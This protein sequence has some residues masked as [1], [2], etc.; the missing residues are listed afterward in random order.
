MS[1]MSSITP[2]TVAEGK[3]WRAC[4]RHNMMA[5][6]RSRLYCMPNLTMAPP[7]K[8]LISLLYIAAVGDRVSSI[9]GV[10][11]GAVCT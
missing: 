9:R 6:P 3:K 10:L 11:G 8:E 4:H 1:M 7:D 5:V 2:S